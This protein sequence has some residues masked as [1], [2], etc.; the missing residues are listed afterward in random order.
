MKINDEKT[1][2]LRSG[3]TKFKNHFKQIAVTFKIYADFEWSL[4]KIH[5]NK[6]GN[7]TSYTG[8]N[9]NHIPCSFAYKVVCVDDSFSKLVVLYRGKNVVYKFIERILEK[10]VCCKKVMNEHFNKNL[11]MSVEDEKY[12]NQ[13]ISV[14][15]VINYLL[16]K[17]KKQKIMIISQEN[18]EFPLIQIVILI[19]N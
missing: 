13:E 9:E 11:V 19:L 10:Y 16:M 3:S 2:K 1:V 18:I 7:D 15:Y 14:G 4:E 5:T 12:F 6:R 17:I 8:K